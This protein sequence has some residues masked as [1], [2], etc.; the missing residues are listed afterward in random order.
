MDDITV[1]QLETQI[2]R[3]ASCASVT[4]P[5]GQL[6][7]LLNLA[8]KKS[9]RDSA[10]IARLQRAA[11]G[12]EVKLTGDE[13]RMVLDFAL[14]AKRLEN[15]SRPLLKVVPSPGKDKSP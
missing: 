2:Q 13:I 15:K 1:E 6:K 5:S 8:M 12:L 7:P 3:A 11:R 4:L 9:L 14:Q 10:T